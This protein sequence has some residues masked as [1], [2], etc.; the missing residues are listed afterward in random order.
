MEWQQANPEYYIQEAR[1]KTP[2]EFERMH[3]NQWSSSLN[4]F[5][6]IQ[7]WDAC[8]VD[9][10]PD[11]GRKGVVMGLDAA[12]SNDSFA[13]VITTII[14]EK[15]AVL[16]CRIWKPPQGGQ[17][18]FDEIEQELLR[19]FKVYNVEEVAYDPQ[20]MTSMSQRLSANVF[21]REFTQGQPR[22]VGDKLLYDL[23]RDRRIMHDG[24][25]ELRQHIMNAHATPEA[26]DK[27]RIVKGTDLTM[28]I[29]ASVA[30]AMS[31][32]RSLYYGF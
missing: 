25:S 5:V 14:D 11:V 7:W 15:V 3:R 31:A 29:D 18:K 10:L 8:R 32:T 1:E 26:D 27:I 24:N 28:K 23:I 2:S 4:A 16:Y 13:V 30:L 9:S 17:I 19:L 6:P 12:R 22:I 21:W 20:D